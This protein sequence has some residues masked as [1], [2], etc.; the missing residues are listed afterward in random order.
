[1]SAQGTLDFTLS[2]ARR[3]YSSMGNPLDGKGIRD[4]L[5]LIDR[6]NEPGILVS[7]DQEKA[8]D[9]VDRSFLLNFSLEDFWFRPMVLHVHFYS[10]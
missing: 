9:R 6:T 10:L 2:N 5:A 7:L 3:F 8:F 4:T 1:M